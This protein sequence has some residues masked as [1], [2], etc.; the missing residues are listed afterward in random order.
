MSSITLLQKETKSWQR[1][2]CD[3]KADEDQMGSNVL[4]QMMV[5]ENVDKESKCMRV[6]GQ[7]EK[8][9]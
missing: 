5:W 8:Q 3:R 1:I 7:F 9:K 6:L 4:V 2:Q